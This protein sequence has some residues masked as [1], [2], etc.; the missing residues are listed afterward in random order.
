M[1]PAAGPSTIKL[2]SPAGIS[3]ARWLWTVAP[4]LQP[5][6]CS[7]IG[8][9]IDVWQLYSAARSVVGGGQWLRNHISAQGLYIAAVS[10]FSATRPSRLL[11]SRLNLPWPTLVLVP[12]LLL[13]R[14]HV[15]QT[16]VSLTL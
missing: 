13:Q 16:G 6:S 9:F 4:T 11:P 14:H 10:A 1:E 7:A 5:V 12:L 15:L 8:V 3:T 2:Q